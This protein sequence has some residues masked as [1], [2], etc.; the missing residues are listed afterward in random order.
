MWVPE[1]PQAARMVG[2]PS[3]FRAYGRELRLAREAAA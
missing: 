3:E 2:Q 1:L